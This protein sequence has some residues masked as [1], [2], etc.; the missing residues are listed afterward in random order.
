MRKLIIAPTSPAYRVK[1]GDENITTKLSGGFSRSRRDQLGAGMNVA[2]SWMVNADGFQYLTAFYNTITKVGSLPF[3]MDLM[4]D[5]APLAE[6]E[7]KFVP[8]SFGLEQTSGDTHIFSAQLEVKPLIPNE[9]ADT[10]Y[11]DMY[12]LY[13]TELDT[14]L[15]GLDHLANTVFPATLT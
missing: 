8:G 1:R 2:V 11:V 13:G 3:L 10:A 12:E 4:I 6:H 5:T 14:V 7:C 9:A 15:A